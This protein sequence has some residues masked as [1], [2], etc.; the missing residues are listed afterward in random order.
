MQWTD[1]TGGVYEY[2]TTEDYDDNDENDDKNHDNR[3]TRDKRT[4]QQPHASTAVDNDVVLYLCAA[5]NTSSF[6]IPAEQT[7]SPS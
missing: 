3:H 2:V 4:Y 1:V 7:F 5:V 6:S